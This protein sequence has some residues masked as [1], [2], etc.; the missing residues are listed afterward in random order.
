MKG[1][2]RIRKEEKEAGKKENEQSEEGEDDK[3]KRKTNEKGKG[4]G[5]KRGKDEKGGREWGSNEKRGV[6]GRSRE[7]IERKKDGVNRKQG[8]L[9]KK[10]KAK[11]VRGEKES[12]EKMQKGKGAIEVRGED[13]EDKS[14]EIEKEMTLSSTRP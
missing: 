5:E 13:R 10:K 12:R 6:K 3:P 14:E 8:M 2:W 4:R 9:W 1:Q 7:G 11:V